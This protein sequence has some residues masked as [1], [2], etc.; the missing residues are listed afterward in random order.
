M[1][2][3]DTRKA[4][5]RAMTVALYDT[6]DALMDADRILASPEWQAVVAAVL[7]DK[8]DA[9]YREGRRAVW[10]ELI[11]R[12]EE[13]LAASSEALTEGGK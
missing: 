6:P 10:A 12:A 9:A 7:R 4:L 3:K 1:T 8:R 5:A 11:E 2:D 13:G